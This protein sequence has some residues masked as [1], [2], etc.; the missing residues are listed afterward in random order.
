MENKKGQT[1]VGLLVFPILILI[2]ILMTGTWLYVF[3]IVDDSLGNQNIVLS[4]NVNLSNISDDTLGQINT[5]FLN[6]ADL[7]AIFFIFGYVISLFVVAYLTRGS[8]PLVFFAIDFLVILFA[9]ILAVYISNSFGSILTSLPYASTIIANMSVSST[10][11]LNLP[12]II[13]ITGAI[14][15]LISYA[16]I[17]RAKEEVV[18]GI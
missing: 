8:T 12:R 7:I 18:P 9:Y 6:G 1:T 15:M 17:P 4:D 13:I 2:F 10:I 5:A 16:G 14:V 3:G 11:M